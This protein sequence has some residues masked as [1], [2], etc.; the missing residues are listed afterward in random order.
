[1]LA[2]I[3]DIHELYE[4]RLQ[5]YVS[6]II[7][8]RPNRCVFRWNDVYIIPALLASPLGIDG[9]SVRRAKWK[10]LRDW[11]RGLWAEVR[12]LYS[13]T[14]KEKRLDENLFLIELL[15]LCFCVKESIK[16]EEKDDNKGNGWKKLNFHHLRLFSYVSGNGHFNEE[17]F[18]RD[19]VQKPHFPYLVNRLSD[20]FVERN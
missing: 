15:T 10:G 12:D 8:I 20:C 14:N 11:R 16:S 1:M 6:R 3:R 19:P 5:L 17:K 2:L 18:N 4:R 9:V 13:E 7:W